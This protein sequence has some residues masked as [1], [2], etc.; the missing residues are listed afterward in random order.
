MSMKILLVED[1]EFTTSVVV[2]ALKNSNYQIETTNDGQIG[3]EL[4]KKVDYD[5]LLLDVSLPGLDGISLCRQI[6]CAGYQ[7]PI[8][9]LTGKDSISMRVT[10]LEAGA[11]DYVAKP[12]DIS[13]LIARIKALLR[14]GKEILP[15]IIAWEN[16]QINTNTK[17]VTYTTKHL[18]LTPKEYGLLELFLRNPHRI[19]SRR[20]LLDKIWSSVEFPGEEAVT[21]QIKGL[22]QK[23][24]IAGMKVDLIETVYGLG[25]R[26]TEEEKDKS[27]QK[28]QG[29]LDSHRGTVNQITPCYELA[30]KQQAEAKVMAVVAN[31]WEEFK[32]TLGEQIKL[33][34]QVQAQLLDATLNHTLLKQATAQ[35]HRLAGSLGCYSLLEG[36]KIAREIERLLEE[37][38]TTPKQS[39]TLQLGELIKS[40]KKILHQ[41]SS[42]PAA[43]S[44][45][46]VSSR[47][48]LIID[49]DAMLIERIELEAKTHGFQVEIAANLKM[50]RSILVKYSP[51]V[52]LLDLSFADSQENGLKLLAELNQ[53]KP[54]IPVLVFTSCNQLSKRVEA[55]SLGACGFLS[56][57]MFASEVI[58][59]VKTA[60][61]Q[62]HITE[63]K[64][65]IVDDDSLVLN[66][67][68]AL[69]SPWRIQLTTLQDSQKF[70]D[71]LE[72]TA[73]DLLILDIEMPD[74][75]G[76]ELCQA[77]RNDPRWNQLAVLFLSVHSDT[78]I[79]RKV[80]AAGAD[81][82]VKKPFVESE[83][84]V[85]ILNRLERRIYKYYDYYQC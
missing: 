14:R 52:I 45:S 36:S 41:Q 9:I 61:N 11:D 72:Y 5:L 64:I 42:M 4:A 73:P 70:W 31:M 21:T 49:D 8:L 79:V 76:I 69:L 26:L 81:D 32:Q 55:A 27:V 63:A 50:A 34:E 39:I 20:A 1:D 2:A 19:Y 40:L 29:I 44:S 24:K 28:E 16:L 48:L 7:M 85:R 3:L 46:R 80:Y 35:A 82:Y 10:G 57:T 6:R 15:T 30:Q 25:Y 62:N 66:H 71:V 54:D 23:L 38:Q 58:S 56:K 47:R 17:E 60:L 67:V 51:D 33:F 37:T 68:T 22:R 77:V 65:L 13:E 78:E 75:S 74:F 83:L 84:I 43:S 18:H 53:S 59:V 12:F